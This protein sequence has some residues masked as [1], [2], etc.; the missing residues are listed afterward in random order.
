MGWKWDGDKMGWGLR[1]GIGIESRNRDEDGDG[2]WKWDEMENGN[3]DEDES[4]DGDGD[5]DGDRNDQTR[6]V[7]SWLQYPCAG[8]L[9]ARTQHRGP[10]GALRAANAAALASPAPQTLTGMHTRPPRRG[11]Y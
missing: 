4:G 5:G 9:P 2:E 3:R 7:P 6:S 10:V 1:M 11:K 8:I